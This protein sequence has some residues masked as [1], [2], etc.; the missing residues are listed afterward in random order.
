M[1]LFVFY[2]LTL[3]GVFGLNI[4]SKKERSSSGRQDGSNTISVPSVDSPDSPDQYRGLEYDSSGGAYSLDVG[5]T[6]DELNKAPTP[7]PLVKGFDRPDY[8]MIKPT[9]GPP[10]ISNS[11]AINSW[12][13]PSY[14]VKGCNP[15][16]NDGGCPKDQMS[17]YSLGAGKLVVA[18]A[19]PS[20][21]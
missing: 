17:Q 8:G 1:K 3:S 14:E 13:P 21:R 10:A 7:N 12:S 18:T 16:S 2:L 11:V 4:R 20:S 6:A 5:S 9:Y 15:S 19:M